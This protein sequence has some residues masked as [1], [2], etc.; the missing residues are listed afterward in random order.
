MSFVRTTQH[1]FHTYDAHHA[2]VN[3]NRPEVY[4]PAVAEVALDRTMAFFGKHL[5]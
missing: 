3:K 2:F 4:N 1:T 5:L